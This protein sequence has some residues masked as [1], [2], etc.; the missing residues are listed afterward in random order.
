MIN[1]PAVLADRKQSKDTSP[2]GLLHHGFFSTISRSNNNLSSRLIK[3]SLSLLLLFFLHLQNSS[4]PQGPLSLRFSRS[5][6]ESHSV[7]CENHRPPRPRLPEASSCGSAPS[8]HRRKQ[9]HTQTWHESTYV[10]YTG[11]QTSGRNGAHGLFPPAFSFLFLNKHSC[12]LEVFRVNHSTCH[13]NDF[14]KVHFCGV[15]LD[16]VVMPQEHWQWR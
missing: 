15:N 5:L 1:Y 12:G 11:N 9:Q 10:V 13:R 8:T 4:R 2:A 6:S 14:C 7:G 3:S 16:S